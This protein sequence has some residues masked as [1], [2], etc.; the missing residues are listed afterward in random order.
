MRR[1]RR[2]RGRSLPCRVVEA[3]NSDFGAY[4]TAL[5]R[6]FRGGLNTEPYESK[7]IQR[8]PEARILRATGATIAVGWL[9][10]R[11]R[12]HAPL[13]ASP[14]TADLSWRS[15]FGWKVPEPEVPESRCSKKFG[16]PVAG[17]GRRHLAPHRPVQTG[18]SPFIV[19]GTS[20]HGIG[21]GISALGSP[22]V[23]IEPSLHHPAVF[24][25]GSPCS[26]A[27]QTHGD[28]Q[29]R[30]SNPHFTGRKRSTWRI[31]VHAIV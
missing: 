6:L 12:K 4:P 21:Q 2:L 11:E 27:Q 25:L 8:R 17:D 24:S 13:T 26:P 3:V 28:C 9:I 31:P 16:G 15:Q 19:G 30:C 20:T 23:R 22:T 5:S 18:A 14:L 1:A 10:R 7:R 29:S